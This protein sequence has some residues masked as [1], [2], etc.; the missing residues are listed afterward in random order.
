MEAGDRKTKTSTALASRSHQERAQRIEK[1]LEQLDE[2]K[3]PKVDEL[4][5]KIFQAPQYENLSMLERE[6]A[7]LDFLSKNRDRWQA[8]L[9]EEGLFAGQTGENIDAISTRCVLERTNRKLIP[10]LVD[11]IRVVDYRFI[12]MLRS[13][14]GLSESL[15][16]DIIDINIRSL[17]R[18]SGRNA[19]IGPFEILDSDIVERYVVAADELSGIVTGKTLKPLKKYLNVREISHCLNTALL[20]HVG[21]YLGADT[22]TNADEGYDAERIVECINDVGTRY[23]DIPVF[24]LKMAFYSHLPAGAEGDAPAV[25]RLLSLFCHLGRAMP[26]ARRDGAADGLEQIVW[27]AALA[28]LGSDLSESTD[29]QLL[30]EL[31]VIA[32]DKDW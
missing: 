31:L 21:V 10:A 32:E 25:S 18:L 17:K 20:L 11:R 12:E 5:G 19:L 8:M 30:E 22:D 4:L 3:F 23:P 2:P 13:T 1:V 14:E 24:L 26:Q 16:L 29:A 9:A 6:Q 27:S 28:D 7:V 15:P